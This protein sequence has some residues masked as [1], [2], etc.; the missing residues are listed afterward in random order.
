MAGLADYVKETASAPGTSTT[1]NLGGATAPFV[2]FASSFANGSTPYYYMQDATQWECGESTLIHG[3]PNTLSRT[4]VLA[5]SVG[6]TAKLNFAGTTT[7]YSALPSMQAVYRNA[8]GD[9]QL[10]GAASTGRL[11]VKD[12]GTTAPIATET[13]GTSSALA[14]G[15]LNGNGVVG[16]ISTNGSST[17]YNTSSDYRLKIIHGPADPSLIAALRVYDAEFISGGARYPMFVAHE[18]QEDGAGWL[19]HGAKD[20]DPM[21]GVDHSKLIPAL[22]AFCQRLRTDLD[23]ALAQIA[24]MGE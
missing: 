19:V 20:G 9:V 21:Q 11:S 1:F 6:T 8:N 23:A 14:M 3:S 24:A 12:D 5:N 17:A 2:T 18:L 22:V 13:P 7:V 16:T 10:G 4:T 15:F